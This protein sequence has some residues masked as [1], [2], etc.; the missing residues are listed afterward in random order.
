[1]GDI[2][3][4]RLLWGKF[5]LFLFAGVLASVAALLYFP[6]VRLAILMGIAIWSFARAYYFLFYVIEHY[7]DP[8][9]RFAGLWSVVR[10]LL[11]NRQAR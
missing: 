9:F 8:S 11:R 1:M 6:S 10:Y 3:D 2:K 5:A 7:I 4:P